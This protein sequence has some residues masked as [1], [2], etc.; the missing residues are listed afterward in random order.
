MESE[1]N[2]YDEFLEFKQSS[3]GQKLLALRPARK[4]DSTRALDVLEAVEQEAAASLDG[5]QQVVCV[6]GATG[7]LAGHIILQLLDKGHVVHGTVRSLKQ[8]S[9]VAHLTCHPNSATHLKLFEADLTK[10]GSYDAAISG[11][12]CVMHVAN[13]V[14]LTSKDPIKDI[15]EPSVNGL[16]TVLHSV[17]KEPLV[18]SFV[19]TS[20][21]AA[22]EVGVPVQP[23]GLL[24][25]A[26]S[27]TAASP[28]WKP[29]SFRCILSSFFFFF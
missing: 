13:V 9:R 16:K 24:T 18:S 7:Y 19:L 4:A 26:D 15:I 12:T 27:N 6:T 20:S 14:Q 21:Y 5:T 22:I 29:Y 8:T 3:E 10:D 17:E 25:E 1:K 28:Q 2:E 11:C 23:R